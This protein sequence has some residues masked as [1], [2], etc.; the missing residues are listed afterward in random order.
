MYC[1]SI[2][3]RVCYNLIP[4]YPDMYFCLSFKYGAA[5]I[6]RNIETLAYSDYQVVQI[7][8]FKQRNKIFSGF[9]YTNDLKTR[10]IYV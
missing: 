5:S 6:I 3:I 1:I 2:N 9:V 4:L 8:E 10:F 7:S